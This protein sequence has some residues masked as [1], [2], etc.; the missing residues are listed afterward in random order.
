VIQ[1]GRRRAEEM[2]EAAA[3]VREIGLEPWSAGGTAERQAFIADLAEAG[4]MGDRLAA[5]TDWRADADR[6]LAA[7][8]RND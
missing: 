1:H 5:R 8:S 4:K 2:R 7:I 6:L 3:T